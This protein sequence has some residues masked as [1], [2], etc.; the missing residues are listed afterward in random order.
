M[1]GALALGS[2]H[3][4]A[5][6]EEFDVSSYA[7]ESPEGYIIPTMVVPHSRLQPVVSFTNASGAH[8]VI[9]VAHTVSCADA[10]QTVHLPESGPAEA[11]A[12]PVFPSI[13]A[14]SKTLPAGHKITVDHALDPDRP[15]ADEE[16]AEFS[17]DPITCVA[18]EGGAVSCVTGQ[19]HGFIIS[20]QGHK[21]W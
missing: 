2:A 1:F 16:Q 6:P 15:N 21:T 13:A 4:S 10:G 12:F 19:G 5:D 11:A 8:C 7:D 9:L 20:G 18:G 14:Q 17:Q 3:A